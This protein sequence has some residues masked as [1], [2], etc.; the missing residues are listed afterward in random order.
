[1]V[2]NISISVYHAEPDFFDDWVSNYINLIA[3]LLINWIVICIH[4]QMEYCHMSHLKII[5]NGLNDR[6]L[7]DLHHLT[8]TSIIIIMLKPRF[9]WWPFGSDVDSP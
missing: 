5:S 1:M 9:L 8:F 2:L 7:L 3:R 4:S 6:K